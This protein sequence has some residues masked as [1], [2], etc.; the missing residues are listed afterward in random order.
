L[1]TTG[2]G[3]K[4]CL[5]HPKLGNVAVEG[6][7]HIERLALRFQSSEI[8][9]E[10][11]MD[12]V[13]VGMEEDGERV[14]IRDRSR[15]GLMILTP[16]P[17]ILENRSFAPARQLRA[18]VNAMA[19]RRE[20]SRRLRIV[21]YFVIGCVVVTALGSWATSVMVR[22]LV[23]RVPPTWEQEFGDSQIR[24]LRA[25]DILVNDSNQLA[26]LTA[27]AAPLTKV[28]P[29]AAAGVKFYIVDDDEPN[30][31]A[32]PGG[33]VVVNTGLLDMVDNPEELMGVLAHEMAHVSERHIA[34]HLISAA[35][36]F[37]IFGVFLHSREGLLNLLS[38][39]SGMMIVQGYSQEY[40][41]EADDVG[42]KYLVAADINPRGMIS[43]FR[44]FQDYEALQR[45]SLDVPQA[46]RSHPALD[47][48]I[49]RLE[50]RLNKLPPGLE[51]IEMTNQVPK[52]GTSGQ[53]GVYR[54]LLKSRAP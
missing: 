6:R 24:K 39:G 2:R 14:C 20:I 30:A 10:I 17:S 42:W 37:V 54:R 49:A 36:P 25:G 16:D 51:F 28:M 13:A 40:E 50:R 3:Y 34:R 35:G 47:K 5:F 41:T 1:N 32:L 46:F 43:M 38:T 11:P 7:I 9:D 45:G 12:R 33:H 23:A 52:P 21:L 15:P 29:G 8:T 22:L 27:L 31:F 26:R 48:R 19:T 4:A 18:E 53:R 44:K